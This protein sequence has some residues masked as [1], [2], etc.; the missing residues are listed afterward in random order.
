MGAILEDLLL[1]TGDD[2]LGTRVETGLGDTGLDSRLRAGDLALDSV[3][4]FSAQVARWLDLDQ[5]HVD[6]RRVGLNFTSHVHLR[7][8]G[9]PVD[10]WAPL[11]GFFPAADGWVRTH[12]NYPHHRRRLGE[13]LGLSAHAGRDDAAAAIAAR[14]AEECEQVAI[15]H[16]GLCVRVRA[17][18][19][20]AAVIP[21]SP[22]LEVGRTGS[23]RRA[24]ADRLRVLDLSRVIAGPTATRA[25]A[26]V[27][28]DVLRIDPPAMPE[29]DEQHIDT[30]AGKRSTDLDLASDLPRFRGLLDEAHVL[31]LG[32]RSGS[33]D[34]YG[35]GAAQLAATHPGLV[36]ASLSAY[37]DDSAWAGRRGFDS[38]VQAA[39]GIARIEGT[40]AEDGS[41]LRP[42]ALRAQALDHATGYIL[43][44]AVLGLLADGAG[45][46]VSA[47]LT[48][49]AQA[50]IGLGKTEHP[51]PPVPAAGYRPD[52]L[53]TVESDYGRITRVRP[54]VDLPGR[55]Q[56]GVVRLGSS[57]AAWS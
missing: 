37:P 28:A 39:S 57:R 35:L 26:L 45:G 49:T 41:L 17:P 7:I 40:R 21:P 22:L 46:R 48:A 54:V 15:A 33:L 27:G 23:P 9:E 13:A 32:Y 44:G 25:L 56:G 38:L 24:S 4:F 16:G 53:E 1:A 19:E 29:I 5:V 2:T 10:A 20:F 42:G 11:S 31:V 43:A 12:A 52:D 6:P 50:L 3:R 51:D 55:T 30:G 36:V 8:D 47:S 34:R 18:H 14:S